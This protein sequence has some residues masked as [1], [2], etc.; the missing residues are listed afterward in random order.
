M[1]LT[2]SR[3]RPDCAP[4]AIPIEI[5]IAR[6]PSVKESA[7]KGVEDF[8]AGRTKPWLEVKKEL[9]L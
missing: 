8:L 9:D 5:E 6:Q 1:T 7:M 3:A 2:A 4:R